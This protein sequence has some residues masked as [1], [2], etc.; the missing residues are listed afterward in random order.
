MIVLVTLKNNPALQMLL[1]LTISVFSQ[2]LIIKSQPY[3]SRLTNIV[4]FFNEFAVSVYLYL[5][6]FLTDF[7]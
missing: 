3:D 4:T 2:T 6:F 7:V 1:L 5:S